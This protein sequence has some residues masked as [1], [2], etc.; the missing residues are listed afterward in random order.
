M[1]KFAARKKKIRFE[2][3]FRNY[4]S[5]VHFIYTNSDISTLSNISFKAQNV[6]NGKQEEFIKMMY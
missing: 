4:G 1:I 6:V 5:T 3:V 2:L